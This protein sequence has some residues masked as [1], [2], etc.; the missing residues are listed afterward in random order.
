LTNDFLGALEKL[1]KSVLHQTFNGELWAPG[2][3]FLKLAPIVEPP[4]P[5]Q[6]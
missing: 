3:G 6:P 1:N 4:A 5:P 2:L